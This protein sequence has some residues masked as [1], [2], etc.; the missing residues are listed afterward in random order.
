MTKAR[1]VHKEIIGYY[2]A[3]CMG[4]GLPL[5][6]RDRSEKKK[7]LSYWW[8]NVNCKRCLKMRK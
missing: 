7:R 4:W 5:K 8:K 6:E 2:F 1:V 3:W